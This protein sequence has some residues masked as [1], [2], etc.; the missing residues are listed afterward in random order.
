MPQH[1][2]ESGGYVFPSLDDLNHFHFC[3]ERANR[4]LSFIVVDVIL[5]LLLLIINDH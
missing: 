5:R 4:F 1:P 3:E 2:C